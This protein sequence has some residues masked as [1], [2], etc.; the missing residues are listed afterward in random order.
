[1]VRLVCQ[2][3]AGS[4]VIEDPKVRLVVIVFEGVVVDLEVHRSRCARWNPL[5]V[6]GVKGF[7]VVILE[8]VDRSV[9]RQPGAQIAGRFGQP[10]LL[11]HGCDL[12]RRVGH[13]EADEQCLHLIDEWFPHG[14][15]SFAAEHGVPKGPNLVD[16]LHAP[17][18]VAAD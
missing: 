16:Q 8:D 4:E 9:A 15:L 10:Q 11:T 6:A 18:R 17:C 1:M 14:L 2:R 12:P 13:A 7:A 3:L 5:G